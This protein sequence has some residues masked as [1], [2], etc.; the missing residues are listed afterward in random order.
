MTT[1]ILLS[2]LREQEGKLCQ[3]ED[4]IALYKA[5]IKLLEEQRKKLCREIR[6]QLRDGPGL[7]DQL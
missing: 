3:I 6:D 2:D 5:E 1:D 4:K 7:Y